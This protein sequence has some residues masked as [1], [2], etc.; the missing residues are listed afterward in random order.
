MNNDMHITRTDNPID[1][2][3]A[4]GDIEAAIIGLRI[5]NMLNLKKITVKDKEDRYY[6]DWGD[7][8]LTGLGRC[9]E[10]IVREA[11]K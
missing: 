1:F 8:T 9:V 11:I 3:K 6:T 2:P 4:I 10:R 5:V 7:K